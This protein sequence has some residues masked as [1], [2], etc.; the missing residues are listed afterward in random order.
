MDF[1]LCKWDGLMMGLLEFRRFYFR[2]TESV[3]RAGYSST[4]E[5]NEVDLMLLLLKQR[6]ATHINI[7]NNARRYHTFSYYDYIDSKS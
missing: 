7:T 1:C 2:Q 4:I 5:E 3:N 6:I